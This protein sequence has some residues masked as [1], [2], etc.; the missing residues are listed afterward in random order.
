MSET[1]EVEVTREIRHWVANHFSVTRPASDVSGLLRAVAD[2]LDSLGKITV[3]DILG[4]TT[5]EDGEEECTL[6]VY[7]S[8]PESTSERRPSIMPRT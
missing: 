6:T 3:H 2:V 1:P 7:L 8:F 4:T 5:V